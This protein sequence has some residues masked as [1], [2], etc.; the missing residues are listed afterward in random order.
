M[1]LRTIL[2]LLLA[3]GALLAVW[4]L[5]E[6]E[7]DLGQERYVKA[8]F[9]D[10]N[11]SEVRAIRIE[12]LAR[13]DT[14][15]L[16]RDSNRRWFLTD[17]L[18]YPADE[19][20][21]ERILKEISSAGGEIVLDPDPIKLGLEP[22]R[23]AIEVS[24]SR[25]GGEF[26][27]EVEIGSLDVDGKFVFVRRQEQVLRAPV[28]LFTLLDLTHQDLRSRRLW[29]LSPLDQII[30][31][32]RSSLAAGP[33]LTDLSFEAVAEGLS[34]RS[35]GEDRALLD[36]QALYHF[37]QSILRMRSERFADDEPTDL[38]QY[39]L[40][41]PH[42]RL[43]LTSARGISEALRFGQSSS[44]L[45]AGDDAWFCKREG[46]PQVWT[47]AAN[48]LEYLRLRLLE[49][50]EY[51]IMR[52]PRSDLQ[53]FSLRR[54]SEE[55][56]LSRET[57]YWLV[58][59]DSLPVGAESSA[60]DISEKP[61][62]VADTG[63]V[64][65]LLSFFEN[66]EVTRYLPGMEFEPGPEPLAFQF[67]YEQDQAW[68]GRLGRAHT[69][70]DGVSGLLYQRDGSS[71]V[72]IL[73]MDVADA[74]RTEA[75]SLRTRVIQ[76]LRELAQHRVIIQRGAIERIYNRAPDA[77][78]WSQEDS[79]QP[80]RAFEEL[81]ARILSIQANSWLDSEEA[82]SQLQD[83]VRLVIEPLD[84]RQSVKFRIGLDDKGRALLERAGKW[85]VVANSLHESLLA[86]P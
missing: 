15:K 78:E 61:G 27:V 36:P 5:H 12:N 40:E 64:E 37:I 60:L 69:T 56:R 33:G 66:V 77:L 76:R 79:N 85:A 7:R 83:E 63:R 39:G 4:S 43:E 22:P 59:V 18:A 10:V 3:V 68:G 74:I 55:V 48:N 6:E 67:E 46:F 30:E 19:S 26:S 45:A 1:H 13:F 57:D 86:L 47:V 24:E 23:I 38:A 50:Y 31:L 28:S 14:V 41:T 51:R 8:V 42:L 62:E 11:V 84:P 29:T 17:P 81:L 21:P 20:L 53:A 44:G 73:G 16:E 72:G 80:A 58:Q 54:A 2:L 65:D 71:L 75:E 9:P 34:W 32:S 82:P 52:G 70:E 35:L 49:F 25:P